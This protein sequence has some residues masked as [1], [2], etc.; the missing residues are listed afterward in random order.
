MVTQHLEVWLKTRLEILHGHADFVAKFSRLSFWCYLRLLPH[1][2]HQITLRAHTYDASISMRRFLKN[3]FSCSMIFST[4]A[5][6]SF[7]SS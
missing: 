5:S 2:V 1:L 4:D 7:Q 3:K 6:L